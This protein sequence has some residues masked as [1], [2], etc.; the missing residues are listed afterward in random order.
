LLIVQLQL[1]HT[2][3]SLI[4][5]YTSQGMPLAV[6]ILTAFATV[7]QGS[8]RCGSHRWGQRISHL[9]AYPP[10]CPACSRVGAGNFHDPDLERSLVSSDSGAGRGDEDSGAGSTSLSWRIRK[11]L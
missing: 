5:L 4:L 8:D 11:R 10:P 9:F 6:F 2:L 1:L 3:W 7:T